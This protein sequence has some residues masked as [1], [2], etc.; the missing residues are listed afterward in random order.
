MRSF[1]LCFIAIII[2]IIVS[3][4]SYYAGKSAEALVTPVGLMIVTP[5]TLFFVVA[6][7]THGNYRIWYDYDI[8]EYVFIRDGNRCS[9]NTMQFRRNYIYKLKEVG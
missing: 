9:V 6:K 4:S 7:E 5:D 8:D 2:L 1:K 3:L